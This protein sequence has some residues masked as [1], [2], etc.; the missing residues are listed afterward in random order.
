[1]KHEENVIEVE[2]VSLQFRLYKEK[3]DSIKEYVLKRAK[4]ELEYE[5]FWALKDISFDVK[6]GEAVGLVGKK[7][8]WKEYNVESNCGSHKT[9]IW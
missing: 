7:W 4:R 8:L 1:M 3:V 9:Y 5:N 6:K 2:N